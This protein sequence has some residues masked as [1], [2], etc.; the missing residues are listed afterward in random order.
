MTFT[1]TAKISVLEAV[2]LESTSSR[3][4][5]SRNSANLRPYVKVDID[6]Y[7]IGK[8][9]A[10][11]RSSAPKWGKEFSTNVE[12]GQNIGFT[13]DLEPRGR[14]LVKFELKGTTYYIMVL[15]FDSAI[16]HTLRRRTTPIGSSRDNIE[17]TS[18]T[19]PDASTC[20]RRALGNKAINVKVCEKKLVESADKQHHF[21]VHS[22]KLPTYCDHC[23]SLLYGII[24]QGLR[25]DA[26]KTNI[27]KRCQDFAAKRCCDA[28]R[29][30]I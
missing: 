6:E 9:D 11:R 8:T 13:I 15:S 26:C 18:K 12:N 7:L 23:G 1:G 16:F 2:N 20:P 27:H 3:S 22:Y 30:G 19:T 14:L 10:I 5:A 28:K 21:S 25:C 4:N 24:R 17:P 29:S